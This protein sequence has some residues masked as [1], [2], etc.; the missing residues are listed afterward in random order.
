LDFVPFVITYVRKFSIRLQWKKKKEALMKTAK[1][2][3]ELRG[4]EIY[5][6]EYRFSTARTSAAESL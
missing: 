6:E 1:K 2:Q 3:Q 5:E 4:L